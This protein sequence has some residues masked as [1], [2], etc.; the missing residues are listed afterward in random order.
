MS[1]RSLS[2]PL[3]E[4]EI[5]Q[6]KTSSNPLRVSLGDIEGLCSSINENGLLQPLIIRNHQGIFEAVAGN[7]RLE[8][9]RRLKWRKVPCYIVELTDKEAF[10]FSLAENVARQSLDPFDEARAFKKYVS[11]NGWGGI[12]ELS[13]HIGRSPSYISK[14]VSLLE[15]SPEVLEKLFRHRKSLSIAEEIMSLEIED[16]L[17]IARTLETT[18]M[19]THEV[20]KMVKTIKQMKSS[21]DKAED[22]L[23][24]TWK[25]Q[26]N[27][28]HFVLKC[29]DQ[30]IS[31]LRLALTRMDGVLDKLESE[32]LEREMLLQYR[33]SLH[34]QLDSLI[35]LKR[36]IGLA[37]F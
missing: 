9:C 8:A 25:A 34:S 13:K 30:T 26:L 33:V 28:R 24:V 17:Q 21:D 29:I 12:T 7:R 20:R 4:V 2:L 35:R 27:N 10:E 5:K 36:K 23:G 11:E 37:E 14:R 15:M 19:P 32:W 22:A 18:P 3:D 31:A 1:L 16:Q 6:I